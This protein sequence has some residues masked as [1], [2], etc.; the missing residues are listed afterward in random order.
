MRGNLR[1]NDHDNNHDADNPNH[2]L[3]QITR[4]CQIYPSMSSFCGWVKNRIISF[5]REENGIKVSNAIK[6][7]LA[8]NKLT[9]VRI[10]SDVI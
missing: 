4:C 1:D 10:E 8:L 6:L 3:E 9:R 7:E 2:A 5:K